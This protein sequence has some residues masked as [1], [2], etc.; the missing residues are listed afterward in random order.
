MTNLASVSVVPDSYYILQ[1][2]VYD[3]EEYVLKDPQ[4][5]DATE[6]RKRDS[7]GGALLTCMGPSSVLFDGVIGQDRPEH[8][9]LLQYYTWQQEDTPSPYVSMSF[10]P[11]LVEIPN[12]TLYFYRRG[13]VRAPFITM[14]FSKSLNHTPCNSIE[15]PERPKIENGVV[16]WPVTLSTDMTSVTYLE[17]NMEYDRND[18]EDFIF[19]SE[20]R[21]AERLQGLWSYVL[22]NC[23]Y[24]ALYS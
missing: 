10:N 24:Y 4:C 19:L 7:E 5:N 8:M 12:I 20:I 18:D 16:V 15:L 22:L 1:S 3:E 23:N 21:V 6:D 11:P 17:I 13:D 14:C 2:N 9:A